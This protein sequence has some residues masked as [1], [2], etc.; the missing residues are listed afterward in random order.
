MFTATESIASDPGSLNAYFEGSHELL[1]AIGD[2]LDLRSVFPRLSEIAKRMLP[3]DAL[4]MS[5]QGEDLNVQLEASSSD[6]FDGV[7]LDSS[8]KPMALELVIGDLAREV[9]PTTGWADLQKRVE[10]GG[11]R[12]LLRVATQAR[13]R[14]VGIAFW[15][16]QAHAYDRRHLPL[17][18]GIVDHLAVGVSHER[19]ARTASLVSPERPRKDNLESRA[20][21]LV[22]EVSSRTHRRIVGVSAEWRAV[23]TEATRVAQTDTTVLVTG[24]SG[25]GKEVIARYI[26]GASARHEGPFVALN[27]AALPEQLLESELFGYERGAFTSAQQPKPGQIELAAGGVLFLD[28]VSEMSLPAQAKF[29]RVLQEREFQRLGGTRTLKANIRV[30][31]ASNRDLHQAVARGTFREDLFY[32]LQVFDIA[33]PPLR[34]RRDDILPLSEAMLQEIGR[35]FGRPPA[36]LTPAAHEALRRHHWPG[37]VR[38]LRNA[39]ERAAIRC[40][41]SLIDAEHLAL[42][43]AERPRGEGSSDLRSVEREI[44]VR[45]LEE[46]RGN[47]ARAAKRL[48]LTRTQ[49]YSRIQKY[50]LE[51][52]GTPPHD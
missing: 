16:K 2:V 11:Y 49:L 34:N 6:D 9:L 26:H 20:R 15:S 7:T 37:N 50:G 43:P 30:I 40:D 24:E 1:H 46:C 41:G 14:R 51:P 23:L 33:I 36:A 29:L 4:T 42:R 44:I 8:G 5:S 18:R 13:D 12:S 25:T 39:L 38:E 22:D 35:S 48:G 21:L 3:H 27:C 47:K 10:A 31:A 17:A 45:V 19:L 28:E 32:R 52:Q